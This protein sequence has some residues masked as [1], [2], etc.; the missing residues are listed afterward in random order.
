M[1]MARLL[2]IL[3]D[4][5]NYPGGPIINYTRIL[6][7]LVQRGYDVH[8]LVLYWEDYPNAREME[9]K[10]IHI[11]VTPFIID[12]RQ[13]V[14]WILEQVEKIQ[15]DVFIPDVSTP[16]CFAGKWI[17]KSGIPVINSHRG[18]D[19]N[20]WGKAIY[21]SDPIYGYDT[22]AIFCVSNFL[23]V[24]LNQK[25]KN[26]DLITAVISSGVPI[27]NTFSQQ[28]DPV[29]IVY[30]GRINQ[31]PKRVIEI[32]NVFVE[33]AK[34]FDDVTFT[35]VGDGPDKPRCQEI[36]ANSGYGNRFTFSGMLKGDVY[37]EE[38]ARHDIVVLLS[39][40]EGM[41]G[42]L[43]DS[44]ASGLVPV[45][46]QYPGSEELVIHGQTGLLVKDRNRSLIEAVSTIIV[47]SH[48]RKRMSQNARQHIIDHYSVEAS[49]EKWEALLN[50]L[51][52]TQTIDKTYFVAPKKIDLPPMNDL[53][54]EHRIVSEPSLVQRL[55][56][57]LRLRTRI[58][59][60]LFKSAPENPVDNFIAIPFSSS[61]LDRYFIRTSIK[62]AL[63][64]ALPRLKGHL[65]DAGCGKMP[66]KDYILKNS[67]VDKYVGL[68]IETALVYDE[69]IKPDFTWDGNTMP[70]EANCFDSC[71][72]TEVLE[73]CHDPEKFL[74]EVYRVLKPE[75]NL[76]FTTPFLWNLHEVPHDEY[77]Y[78]PYSLERH[79]KNAGFVEIE[80]KATGGW[81]ASMAQMMGLWVRRAPISKGKR[82]YLSV[83]L[84]P[85][86]KALIEKDKDN[87][88]PF[89]K[90]Q[91]ITG[92][93]G[94]ARKK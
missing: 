16:G 71:M 5:P 82:R 17:K 50:L 19:D 38:L 32:T 9:A 36:V 75:G 55:R 23:L 29:S 47:D 15:P 6:P 42:S 91:M 18:P 73:H 35:F 2:F 11:H 39:D 43:M 30:I 21:F 20:N 79:L 69:K 66:Y 70:F 72:A 53:L 92:L 90:S 88:Y 60:F 8:V 63:D 3:Y 84:K 24:Q 12:S 40:Y 83:L 10:G 87:V 93:Y 58:K 27:P 94:L 80:I 77:R 54:K 46:Y 81:H 28:R 44:M 33:L 45:C 61:N 7:A 52:E 89:S 31:K 1:K 65:L 34:R 22:S 76:F 26:P 49:I 25:I 51:S 59:S 57:K 56:S 48:L 13:A 14:K 37:K 64:W 4:R 85:V 62:S 67:A 68:D 41:P 86:I 78:T 74:L